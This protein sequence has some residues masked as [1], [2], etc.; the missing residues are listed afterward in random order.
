MQHQFSAHIYA[1]FICDPGCIERAGSRQMRKHTRYWFEACVNVYQV[2]KSLVQCLRVRDKIA[3]P[4]ELVFYDL[5]LVNIF[6]E[7]EA[8]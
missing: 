6:Y 7:L 1:D 3:S 2:K 4:K 5:A 8:Q